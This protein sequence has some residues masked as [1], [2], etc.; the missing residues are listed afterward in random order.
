MGL[1]SGNKRLSDVSGELDGTATLGYKPNAQIKA[2]VSE[3]CF[4]NYCYTGISA[5]V[6]MKSKKLVEARVSMNDPSAIVHAYTFYNAEDTLPS[7]QATATLANVDFHTIGLDRKRPDYRFGAKL[8]I[9]IAGRDADSAKGTIEATDIRWLNLAGKGLQIERLAVNADND[10]GLQSMTIDSDVLRGGITGRYSFSSI[11]P[12]MKGILA[13]FI[14]AVFAA[15]EP[16][17]AAK[18]KAKQ[19]KPNVL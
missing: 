6:D 15:P 1:L 16:K 13:R 11:L 10:N 8:N 14:P 5:S 17:R 3:L 4:D 7:I 19:L 9:N 2:T 12:E 18:T